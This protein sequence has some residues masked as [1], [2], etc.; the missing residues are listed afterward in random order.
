MR[1]RLGFPVVSAGGEGR[2]FQLRERSSIISWYLKFSSNIPFRRERTHLYQLPSRRTTTEVTL[3]KL[4]TTIES[5]EVSICC[6]R[7]SRYFKQ[8]EE[9]TLDGCTAWNER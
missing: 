2:P 3:E 4:E 9:R 5:R 6:D 8:D 7:D 1:V